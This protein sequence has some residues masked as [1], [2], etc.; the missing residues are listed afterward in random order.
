LSGH[1]GACERSRLDQTDAMI[2]TGE[3]AAAVAVAA[4][5]VLARQNLAPRVYAHSAT[6]LA[7]IPL[8]L[9]SESV[10]CTHASASST[11]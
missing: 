5:L 8:P 1:P 6:L 4:R 11:I 9:S 10:L 3:L 2:L 7:V